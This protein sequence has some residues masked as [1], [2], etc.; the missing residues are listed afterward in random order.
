MFRKVI[1]S[2]QQGILIFRLERLRY[3]DGQRGISRRHR[4]VLFEHP[5]KMKEVCTPISTR[6]SN[7]FSRT[8]TEILPAATLFR[9]PIDPPPFILGSWALPP[10]VST[11]SSF[12][13]LFLWAA[14]PN[15]LLV[16]TDDRGSV[17]A[18]C[19]GS[20]DLRRRD[21]PDCR[22][23]HPFHQHVRPLRHLLGLPGSLL[24]VAFLPGQGSPVTSVRPRVRPACRPPK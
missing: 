15:V 3:H 22:N 21:R 11:S 16:Y 2:S 1:R 13:C 18:R 23:G 8:R 12:A 9:C 10:I 17:D 14:K 19:Y 20:K 6:L 5:D 24:T 4:R 7:T